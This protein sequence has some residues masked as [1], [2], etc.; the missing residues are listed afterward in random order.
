MMK[1][2]DKHDPF[3]N[4]KKQAGYVDYGGNPI[5]DGSTKERVKVPRKYKGKKT[6]YYTYT[7]TK[8]DQ[9]T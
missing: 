6:Y 5:I 2:I 4:P 1:P 9:R 8:N 3:E 7:R